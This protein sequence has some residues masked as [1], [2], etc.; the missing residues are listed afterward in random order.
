MA[1]KLRSLFKNIQEK[2][3]E[4]SA[5]ITSVKEC[6]ALIDQ[7]GVITLSNDS[8]KNTFGI[9]SEGKYYWEIIRDRKSSK[10]IENTIKNRVSALCETEIN[11]RTFI[12]STSPLKGKNNTILIFYDITELKSIERMKKEFTINISHELRTPLTAIKGFAETLEEEVKEDS[13][14]YLDIIKRHT[15]RMINIV[16]D[17]LLIAELE[18]E[19]FNKPKEKVNLND[20]I[21]NILPIFRQKAKEKG[22]NLIFSFDNEENNIIGDLYKLEQLFINLIDNAIKYTEKGEVKISIIRKENEICVIVKD[23][24]IGIPSKDLSRIFERFYVVDKSRSR[25]LGG[26]GLGLSIVKHIVNLHEGKIKIKSELYKGTEIEVC[27]KKA[28]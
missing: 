1:R 14:K 25:K 3:T 23:T 15:D 19:N 22:I 8:F 24:G 10:T 13:K 4:I 17:L 20:I 5:I 9:N 27:F 2:Q 11:E 26:T 21:K 28:K 7:K 18:N 12:L 6:I 16:N